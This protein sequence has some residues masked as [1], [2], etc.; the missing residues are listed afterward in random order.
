[1]VS[2]IAIRLLMQT[3]LNVGSKTC[4]HAGTENPVSHHWSCCLRP[5]HPMFARGIT[6]LSAF[7]PCYL[8]FG[9]FCC[10]I[11]VLRGITSRGA[12][13][14][15]PAAG[16]GPTGS[17]LPHKAFRSPN[18]VDRLI[19][20]RRRSD[21]DRTERYRLDLHSWTCSSL[22]TFTSRGG[23]SLRRV[24]VKCWGISSI[25]T[26]PEGTRNWSRMVIGQWGVDRGHSHPTL[27]DWA[28]R[29]RSYFIPP[30]MH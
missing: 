1:M 24:Q 9:S 15:R 12:A 3:V 22:L 5:R 8:I 26:V 6:T 25:A 30:S 2:V 10:A 14:P 17:S 4:V 7:L 13:A 23:C 19:A 18:G 11:A 27:A 28:S 16:P 20:P 29:L 21:G